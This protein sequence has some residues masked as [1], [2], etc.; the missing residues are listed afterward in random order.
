MVEAM[1]QGIPVLALQKG[2]ALEI[3]AEGKTGEF[4]ASNKSEIIAE[5]VRRFVEKEKEYDKNLIRE[6]ARK[7]SKERFIRE[8]EEYINH[9]TCSM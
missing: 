8:F 6:S 9:I 1:A 5:C 7:F 3:V 2:G 4:F